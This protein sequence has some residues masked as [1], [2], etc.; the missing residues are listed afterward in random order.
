MLVALTGLISLLESLL[1]ELIEKYFG[2]VAS[3]ID[4]IWSSWLGLVYRPL[5]SGRRL[6]R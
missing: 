3:T 1:P 6:L 2:G 4:G 5:W